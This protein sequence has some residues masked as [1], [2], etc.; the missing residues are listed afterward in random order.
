MH[1]NMY[2]TNRSTQP[3]AHELALE[4]LLDP[5]VLLLAHRLHQ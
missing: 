5:L 1:K 2:G 4:I 3:D